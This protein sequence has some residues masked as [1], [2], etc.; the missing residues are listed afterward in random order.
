MGSYTRLCFPGRHTP[1]GVIFLG[2]SQKGGVFTIRH[3]RMA[4]FYDQAHTGYDQAQ[5]LKSG[6]VCFGVRRM[7]ARFSQSWPMRC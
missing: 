4:D 7:G 1:K 3:K 6:T 5:G 2:V